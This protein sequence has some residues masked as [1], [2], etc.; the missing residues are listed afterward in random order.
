MFTQEPESDYYVLKTRPVSISCK[1]IKAVQV[2]FYCVGR[3]VQ[4]EHHVNVE[5]EDRVTGVHYLQTSIEV[6][7]VDVQEY[8]GREGYWCEC[9]AWN[10]PGHSPGNTDHA[11][12]R[13]TKSRRTAVHAACKC[14]QILL[15][16]NKI[17]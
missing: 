16:I 15:K 1:V 10:S 2:S 11:G 17:V 8:E 9:H 14:C 3:W 4:P 6:S 7:Q 12:P 13:L 5:E